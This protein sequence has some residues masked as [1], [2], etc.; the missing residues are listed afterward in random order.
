MAVIAVDA[1]AMLNDEAL[2]LEKSSTPIASDAFEVI[3]KP[4]GYLNRGLLNEDEALKLILAGVSPS[5]FNGS[6]HNSPALPSSPAL[7]AKKQK[8]PRP[9]HGLDS[10]VSVVAAKND[11]GQSLIGEAGVSNKE[12]MVNGEA[13]TG[14]SC[15][16]S[17]S[18]EI[19]S[20]VP[21]EPDLSTETSDNN[22]AAAEVKEDGKVRP[23]KVSTRVTILI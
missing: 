3:Q 18:D 17:P 9:N 22:T 4:A 15:S 10:N 11:S 14:H 19:I 5:T 21:V 6:S 12:M 1:A 13:T 8:S 2:N 20:E 16:Q 7:P 23:K